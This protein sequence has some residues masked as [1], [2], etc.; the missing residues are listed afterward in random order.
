[1]RPDVIIASVGIAL[2]VFA[3]FAI[4]NLDINYGISL[5]DADIP[6]GTEAVL[7]YE[8]GNGYL[9]GTVRNIKLY[10]YI[11]GQTDELFIILENLQSGSTVKDI[12]NIPTSGVT[13]GEHTVITRLEYWKGSQWY[14]KYLTLKLVVY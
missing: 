7:I 13:S 6:V 9:S 10:Y 5:A 2:F 14:A 8:I 11:E 12:V 4:S 1:M 3:I